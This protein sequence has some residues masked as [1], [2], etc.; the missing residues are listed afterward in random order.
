VSTQV[1]KGYVAT[2]ILKASEEEEV[3]LIVIGSRG[4]GGLT[5]WFLGSVTNHVVNHCTKPIL[6]VK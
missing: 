6:V 2:K 4:L 5:G 3:D 1:K